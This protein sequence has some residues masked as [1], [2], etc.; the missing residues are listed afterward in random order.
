MEFVE[1]G[2]VITEKPIADLCSDKR[3]WLACYLALAQKTG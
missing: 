3:A 2:I 1:Y